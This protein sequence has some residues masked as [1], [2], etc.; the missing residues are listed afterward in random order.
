[1]TITRRGGLTLSSRLRKAVVSSLFIG[2]ATVGYLSHGQK[3]QACG[4]CNGNYCW[5]NWV[6]AYYCQDD[7]GT[8]CYYPLSCTGS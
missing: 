8:D 2:A 6:S 3:A 7:F 5:Q 1:M 4:T